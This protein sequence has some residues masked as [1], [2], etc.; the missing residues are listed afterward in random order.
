MC[1]L[2]MEDL[3]CQT[4]PMTGLR[5]RTAA[6]NVASNEWASTRETLAPP[7]CASGREAQRKARIPGPGVAG[8]ASPTRHACDSS[9]YGRAGRRE[10]G[11]Q[12]VREAG[13]GREKPFVIRVV[14]SSRSGHIREPN[15]I[16]IRY[17]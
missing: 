10:T 9:R 11:R 17:R 14:N 1:L 12:R 4:E 16:D 15:R 2:G 8:V 13:R 3:G 5:E 7:S 6:F